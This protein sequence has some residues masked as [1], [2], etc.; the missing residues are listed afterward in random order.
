M[1]PTFSFKSHTRSP[2]F[3]SNAFPFEKAYLTPQRGK[4]PPPPRPALRSNHGQQTRTSRRTAPPRSE[5]TLHSRAAPLP[6]PNP[7]LP[8]PGEEAAVL[9]NAWPPAVTRS[10]LCPSR[11]TLNQQQVLPALPPEPKHFL[12]PALHCRA[13]VPAGV[14]V[15][16]SPGSRTRRAL[17][18]PSDRHTECQV[19]PQA[20]G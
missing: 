2:K 15:T 7:P 3:C 18:R 6:W 11:P 8:N 20:S 14:S 10:S 4:N 9:Q 17:R 19:L 16:L 5:S 1:F 12:P 13:L